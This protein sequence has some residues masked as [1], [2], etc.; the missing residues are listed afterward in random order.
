[1]TSGARRQAIILGVVFAGL[2][3]FGRPVRAET[4]ATVVVVIDNVARVPT[5]ILN[6]A[7]SE[8]SRVYRHSGVEIVWVNSGAQEYPATTTNIR[9]VLLSPEGA[10]RFL[11]TEKA[12]NGVLGQAHADA[13]QIYVFWER[14]R[15]SASRFGGDGGDLLGVVLA[16]E[17]GHILLSGMAH[18]PEGIMQA[19]VEPRMSAAL[20]FTVEQAE[21]IRSR[22]QAPEAWNGLEA[23][24][25]VK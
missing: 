25:L 9:V 21:Q 18:S 8:A 2:G 14:V 3:L 12:G 11:R 6:G 22:L 7:K 16:H 10:S 1:M 19:I 24:L 23:S 5:A 15:A 17:I 4:G 13:R 20:R